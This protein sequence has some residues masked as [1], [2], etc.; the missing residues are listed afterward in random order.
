MNLDVARQRQAALLA[1]MPRKFNSNNDWEADLEAIDQG[2]VS[3]RSTSPFSRDDINPN[4]G[5]ASTRRVSRSGE[6]QPCDGK[7]RLGNDS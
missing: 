1:A 7:Y 5:Q 4:V 6:C 2:S 3:K